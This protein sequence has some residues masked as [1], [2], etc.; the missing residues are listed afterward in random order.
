VLLSK[1]VYFQ[2]G[3]GISEKHLR[4]I[5]GMMKVL[6]EKLDRVYISEWAAKLGVAT[7]WTLVRK[8]VGEAS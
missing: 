1:L 7:E 3:G 5:A 6:R 4:D 8:R 2:L